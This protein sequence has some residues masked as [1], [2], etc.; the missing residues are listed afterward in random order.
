MPVSTE[1]YTRGLQL[2]GV[3]HVLYCR[4][5][6]DNRLYGERTADGGGCRVTLTTGSTARAQDH[7]QRG[8]L[9]A[10]R[11]DYRKQINA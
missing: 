3:L 10:V 1:P 6:D 7:P 2:S 5:K 4:K 9:Q 8:A 11:A